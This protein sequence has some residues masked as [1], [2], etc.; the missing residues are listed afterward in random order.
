MTTLSTPSFFTPLP[1]GL[2]APS[3][4]F[5]LAGGESLNVATVEQGGFVSLADLPLAPRLG[6]AY[7]GY[8]PFSVEKMERA[9]KWFRA[10]A[11]DLKISPD[12]AEALGKKVLSN[13]RCIDPV[14]FRQAL[15][16][17]GMAVKKFVGGE[18]YRLIINNPFRSHG[19]VYQSL[20]AMGLVPEAAAISDL[21][22]QII[23]GDL[24]EQLDE[25][26]N[27]EL[28]VVIL[29]D[30]A[31]KGNAL[32]ANDL[33]GFSDHDPIDTARIFVGL[34]AS[35]QR[36]WDFSFLSSVSHYVGLRID[37][38]GAAFARK[39]KKNLG[40]PIE[41]NFHGILPFSDIKPSTFTWYKMPDNLEN[42]LEP[43]GLKGITVS[44]DEQGNQAL[45]SAQPLYYEILHPDLLTSFP[46]DQ[47]HALRREVKRVLEVK[48]PS[49]VAEYLQFVSIKSL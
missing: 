33:F 23:S 48:G 46:P 6:E 16:Q 7:G 27:E 31:Y 3:A 4:E 21:S 14:T 39:E 9:R 30:C 10:Q 34:V 28:K 20:R 32:R 44:T 43:C 40:R 29:D 1:A 47:R 49:G 5:M 42:P 37:C 38:L 45:P 26:R 12:R 24:F 18:P 25:I 13:L 35:T 19:F 15:I 22:G 41:G 2:S 36:G 11:G 8:H 17:M